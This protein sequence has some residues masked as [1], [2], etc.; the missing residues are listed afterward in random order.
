MKI[1]PKR[2]QWPKALSAA[3]LAI[4]ALVE[5]V[6]ADA[7]EYVIVGD[8]GAVLENG[9]AVLA[10]PGAGIGSSDEMARAPIAAGRFRFTG[11]ATEPSVVTIAAEDA[12]GNYKGG[13]RFIL[14]S[15]E[16]RIN[17]AGPLA[18]FAVDGGPYN[19]QLI[20][21]WHKSE[22]YQRAAAE[23]ADVMA[24]RADLQEGPEHD[25]LMAKAV[26]LQNER[27]GI[28][29]TAL[30]NI[31]LSDDDPLASF[32]A[33]AMGG[34]SGTQALARLDELEAV[35]ELP[36]SASALRARNQTL[37]RMSANMRR[38]ATDDEIDDFSAAGLDGETYRLQ[39][40]LADNKLVLI[41]FW[42]SWCGPCR[43]DVPN[44]RAA[45]DRFG[46]RGFA[47]FAFSLDTDR[48]DWKDASLQDGL[49]WINTS[50]LK[51]YDSPVSQQFAV[52]MLPK[53]LLVDGNGVVVEVHARGERLMERLAAELGDDG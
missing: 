23:Y 52:S 29:S 43:A 44:L 13:T 3:I 32:L 19:Q 47:I 27:N 2:H 6:P 30:R 35:V 16:T 22:E 40:T 4:V 36:A 28:R 42:A 15:G 24:E 18:G 38:I 39:D 14:E 41:E 10:R 5:V 34:L 20:D 53:N 8:I 45:V 33:I 7:A 51:G 46:D 1:Q 21:P 50:D 49:T 11:D 37:T 48:E 17:Y 26:R 25:A 9:E 12:A 31:A